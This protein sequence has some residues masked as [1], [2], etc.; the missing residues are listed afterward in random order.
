MAAA[1]GAELVYVDFTFSIKR[2]QFLEPPEPADAQYRVLWK[3]GKQ[4]SGKTG[5]QKAE[6]ADDKKAAAK[7]W[8][9]KWNHD[10]KLANAHIPVKAATPPQSA[11][12]RP[13]TK[14]LEIKLYRHLSEHDEEGEQLGRTVRWK[15]EYSKGENEKKKAGTLDIGEKGQGKP[16]QITFSYLMNEVPPERAQQAQAERRASRKSLGA[17]PDAVSG[18]T[19]DVTSGVD[20]DGEHLRRARGSQSQ[21]AVRS[22]V[23][24]PPVPPPRED[25]VCHGAGAAAVPPGLGAHFGAAPPPYEGD[26]RRSSRHAQQQQYGAPEGHYQSGYQ[27]RNADPYH[28]EPGGGGVES[29]KM[30]YQILRLYSK[31]SEQGSQLEE[32]RRDL[33]QMHRLYVELKRDYE[34]AQEELDR[35]DMQISELSDQL[36]GERE[37]ILR[38]LQ[39][40][41]DTLQRRSRSVDP[42]AYGTAQK[43]N[44][45]CTVL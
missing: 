43:R 32:K 36:A 10:E 44:C 26:S 2:L 15:L 27:Q 33:R 12:G 39:T 1:K 18:F 9:V 5:W 22:S 19:T 41:H 21:E 17:S 42:G 24:M 25:E 30:K 3:R 40:E 34:S 11:D 4:W 31:L 13:I 20:S 45:E 38:Q 7:V 28:E 16:M 23:S 29:E 6:E 14:I 37:S 35:R 8:R